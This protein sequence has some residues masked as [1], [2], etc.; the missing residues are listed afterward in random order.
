[1]MYQFRLED[2]PSSKIEFLKLH[3]EIEE[4]MIELEKNDS[5]DN[6]IEEGLDVIQVILNVYKI[7]GRD[8]VPNLRRSYGNLVKF[9]CMTK[10]LST[11]RNSYEVF[12]P[13]LEKGLT[14]KYPYL[15]ENAAKA[16][17]HVTL[18]ALEVRGVTKEMLR[19]GIEKHN[20][21]L[22]SRG[23]ILEPVKAGY[24]LK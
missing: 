10:N 4:F 7:C 2:I 3:E 19:A 9:D 21:K 17:M 20:E 13:K 1:M 16:L 15:Q 22:R 14:G 5:M 6:I 18:E 8:G 12:V 23:W 24:T 11:L